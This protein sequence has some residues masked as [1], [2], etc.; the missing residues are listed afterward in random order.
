MLSIRQAVSTDL[1]VIV[2][3]LKNLIE[4]FHQPYDAARNEAGVH[5]VLA[6]PHR[7]TWYWIAEWDGHPVG[8]LRVEILWDDVKN[9]E[10]WHLQR[11][12]VEPEYRRLRVATTLQIH[13]LCEAQKSGKVV[14]FTCHIHDWNKPCQKLKDGLGWFRP[15][16][17][18][19]DADLTTIPEGSAFTIALK[20]ETRPV[21]PDVINNPHPIWPSA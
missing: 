16:G 12:Y 7:K 8:M 18:H 14:R 17:L 15:I 19:Y 20:T 9:G 11:M 13:A 10:I 4:L 2:G 1:P 21:V 6:N 3:Y 5:E